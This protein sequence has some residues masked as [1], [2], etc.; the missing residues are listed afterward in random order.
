MIANIILHALTPLLT[1][2]LLG[3]LYRAANKPSKFDV[4]TGE[5]VLSYGWQFRAM[6]W[7]LVIFFS[8]MAAF[9]ISLFFTNPPTPPGTIGF[10]L[11]IFGFF[12]SL[13]IW[14]LVEA[15]SV[16]IVLCDQSITSYCAWRLPRTIHWTDVDEV[17]FSSLAQWFVVKGRQ[18]E[19]IRVSPLISGIGEFASEVRSRLPPS[20]YRRTRCY[21]GFSVG[22]ENHETPRS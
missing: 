13:G 14:L 8:G 18:G 20:A 22:P 10:C 4:F 6:A 17:S 2:L 9:S 15:I 3:L 16:R 1:A 12:D 5:R 11:S 7:S 19:K 21:P